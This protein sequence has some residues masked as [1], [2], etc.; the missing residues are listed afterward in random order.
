MYAEA[1]FVRHAGEAGADM[2]GAEDVEVGRRFD[3][4][5]EDLHLAAADETRLLREVVRELVLHRLRAPR[6]DRLARLP[7]GVVLVAAAADRPDCAAVGEHQ[8]LCPDA[9]RGRAG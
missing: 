4:L 1:G 6:L 3:R 8:H 2:T 9:L 5:D 7:E